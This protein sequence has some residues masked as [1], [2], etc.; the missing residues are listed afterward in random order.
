MAK[1][2]IDRFPHGWCIRRADGTIATIQRI[3]GFRPVAAYKIAEQKAEWMDLSSLPSTRHRRPSLE[4][5]P[6]VQLN[7]RR[8]FRGHDKP[9]ARQWSIY[10]SFIL[11]LCSIVEGGKRKMRWSRVGVGSLDKLN[12][13]KVNQAWKRVYGVWAWS[14]S[15]KETVE[16]Q[17]IFNM[18]IPEDV[19]SY[20]GLIDYPKSPSVS[21]LRKHLG[22]EQKSGTDIM[23]R[24]NERLGRV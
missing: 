18:K 21:E 7:I 6:K 12:Q 2:R 24:Q 1:H 14:T 15:L 20:L 4:K 3:R 19:D 11:P 16:N 13:E 22:Y 10:L 8:R 23:A 17:V 9:M 5:I